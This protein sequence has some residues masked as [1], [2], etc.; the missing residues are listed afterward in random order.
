MSETWQLKPEQRKEAKRLRKAGL[1]LEE[2]GKTFGV[3]KVAVSA[4]LAWIPTERKAK[5]TEANAAEQSLS[6][7]KMRAEGMLLKDIAIELGVSVQRAFVLSLEPQEQRR[8]QNEAN[9]R[10][11][12]TQNRP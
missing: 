5:E 4:L 10:R 6:A 7:A 8:R 2:I 12:P 11:R 3:S 1:T 9:A